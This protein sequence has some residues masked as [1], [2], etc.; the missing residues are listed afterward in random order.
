[1]SSYVDSNGGVS[2]VRFDK[3]SAFLGAFAL[4]AMPLGQ[5][6][7]DSYITS[8][9]TTPMDDTPYY[10]GTLRRLYLQLAAGQFTRPT[11]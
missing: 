9:L 10:Q 1:V 6:K 11:P 4:S 8:W 5:S 2:G 3:N 7:L